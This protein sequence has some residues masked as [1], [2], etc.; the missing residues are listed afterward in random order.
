MSSTAD[1]GSLSRLHDI[2]LPDAVSWWPLAPGWYAVFTLTLL[3]LGLALWWGWHRWHKRRYRRRA[4][5]ELRRLRDGD[6]DL[7]WAATQILILLKR[8]ALAAYP[9]AQVAGLSGDP[10]W[11]FLDQHATGTEF[12]SDIGPLATELAYASTPA[13]PAD[14]AQL[15]ALC[16]AA[17]RWIV[18]HRGSE[19]F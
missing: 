16:S 17:E 5:A 18:T 11:A 6:H 9:R 2:V 13:E 3:L 8:T 14:D 12:V 4:L 10:W 15:R 7:R 1:P 19:R